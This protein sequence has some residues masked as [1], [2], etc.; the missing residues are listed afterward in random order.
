MSGSTWTSEWS[1]MWGT[2]LSGLE[3]GAGGVGGL[4]SA[5]DGTTVYRPAYDGNGNIMVWIDSSG[6]NLGTREYDPFG[7]TIVR[8]G[9]LSVP[10]GFSTKYEDS[11]TGLYYY[12]YR[13]YD[14]THGRWINR[15][16]IGEV[17]GTN[18]YACCQN[19]LVNHLDLLRL[20]RYYAREGGFVRAWIEDAI[21]EL[22]IKPAEEQVENPELAEANRRAGQI[23]GYGEAVNGIINA[24]AVAEDL[25]Q[26]H[27]FIDREMDKLIVDIYGIDNVHVPDYEHQEGLL[28]RA[29]RES[30]ERIEKWIEG[31]IPYLPYADGQSASFRFGKFESNLAIGSIAILIPGPDGLTNVVNSSRVRP[32]S[33][34][35][36]PAR[37]FVVPRSIAQRLG[38]FYRR[39]R[40]QGRAG[41]AEEALERLRSTLDEVEDAM[42]GIS[43]KVPPPPP[44]V[45]DGRMYPPLDDFV[46]KMLME[47]FRQ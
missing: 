22:L 30:G 12:G 8:E 46:K 16:P 45:P 44:G 21:N 25:I 3:Q 34:S 37:S 1:Y 18:L 33:P 9:D 15:D 40:L 6:T 29:R 43:K 5:Y 26:F 7:N 13:Y 10:F 11:E 23:Y 19:D 36:S 17:G 47:A 31:T 35:G 32:L 42:S 39:L 28:Q 20:S 14:P 41:S 4:L 38:E 27:N 2:D 24:P